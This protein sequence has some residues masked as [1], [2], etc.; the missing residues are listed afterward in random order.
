LLEPYDGSYADFRP[1]HFGTSPAVVCTPS[2][3][4]FPKGWR[5]D[6]NPMQN[7]IR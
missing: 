5:T 2:R 4:W 6:Q 3:F 7:R 1:V